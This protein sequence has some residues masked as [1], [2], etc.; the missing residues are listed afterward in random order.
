MSWQTRL[1]PY[2]EQEPLWDYTE[3][4]YE[5]TPSPFN[6]PPH[7]GL[8]TVMRAYACPSDTRAFSAQ[9]THGGIQ[10]ALTS[11]LG[12]SGTVVG[13]NDGV[14]FLDSQVAFKDICDGTSNTVIVGERPASADCWYGWWYAGLGQ[15]GTGSA[16]MILGVREVNLGDDYTSGC[17]L[18]PY[19]FQP[20]NLNQQSDL[21]HFWS[22]HSG[23]AH[24]AFADGSVHFLSYSVDDI[25]PALATRNGR[26][27]VTAP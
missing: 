13:R 27:A 3:E 18:G 10:V 8:A 26:E 5:I 1:L 14:F 7:V 21:F 11:Y 22:L 17:P 4:A 24:F 19:H 6:N 12:V 20:G 9:E 16:D 23:G 15:H 2:L 25:L